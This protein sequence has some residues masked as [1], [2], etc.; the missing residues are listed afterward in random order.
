MDSGWSVKH[1]APA[2]RDF[3]HL[4]AVLEMTD[5][6]AK[7]VRSF[8]RARAAVAALRASFQDVGLSAANLT[9]LKLEDRHY[10]PIPANVATRFMEGSVARDEVQNAPCGHVHLSRRSLPFPPRHV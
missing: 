6:Y 2:H 7:P 4:S 5:L 10:P 3:R 9:E 1:P 8:T